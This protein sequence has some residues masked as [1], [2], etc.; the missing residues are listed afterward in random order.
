M[1]RLTESIQI[2]KYRI[3]FQMT[4]IRHLYVKR[5]RVHTHDLLLHFL[6][7]ARKDVIAE[8][9]TYHRTLVGY[10]VPMTEREDIVGQRLRL[11]MR[12]AQ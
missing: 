2:G 7:L 11:I 6:L 4:G 5:I 3:S 1:L 10:L 8:G 9:E 12:S